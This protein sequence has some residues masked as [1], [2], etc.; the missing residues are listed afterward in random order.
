MVYY[1]TLW[2]DLLFLRKKTKK[3]WLHILRF[4]LFVIR[5]MYRLGS[6]KSLRKIGNSPTRS[7]RAA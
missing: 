7:P 4:W 3:L 1:L 5:H 6:E 2:L